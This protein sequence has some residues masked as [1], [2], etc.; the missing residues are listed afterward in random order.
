MD[1]LSF[2]ASLIAVLQAT[3]VVLSICYSYA[4]TTKPWGL[5]DEVRNLGGVL[6]RLLSLARQDE[7]P[8]L[9]VLCQPGGPLEKTREFLE[10]LECRL[11]PGDSSRRRAFASALSWPLREAET[12]RAMEDIGRLKSTLSLALD[13]D[14]TSLILA[15]KETASVSREA[16]LDTRDDIGCIRQISQRAELDTQRAK[17]KAWLSAPDP[18]TNHNAAH[19]KRQKGTG[20]WFLQSKE[21]MR[22]RA[23]PSSTLWLHGIAG[24]GKTVLSSL[25]IDSMLELYRGSSKTA[26]VYFYF[27]FQ[28]IGKRSPEA[29]LRSLVNQLLAAIDYIPSKVE[30]LF[31]SKNGQQPTTTD[32]LEVFKECILSFEE[33]FII[34]DAIDECAERHLQWDIIQQITE[35]RLQQQHLLLTGRGELEADRRFQSLPRSVK[36][37][38]QSAQVDEDIRLYIKEQLLTDRKLK[39]W[40]N[41]AD[42]K[43]EI[44][45]EL[46]NKAHGMFRWA[47]CQLDA[48]GNCLSPSMLRKRLDSLPATMDDMYTQAITEIDEEHADLVVK[49]LKWLTYSARPL[50]V[51]E[52][53]EIATIDDKS[54]QFNHDQRLVDP[55]DILN[56]CPS[57]FVATAPDG[58]RHQSLNDRKTQQKVRLAHLSVKEFLVSDRIR[59]GPAKHCALSAR[60]AHAVTARDCLAYLLQFRCPYTSIPDTVKSSPLLSYATNYWPMHVTLSG[61]DTRDA[62]YPLVLEL[63]NSKTA[64]LNWASFLD[65]YTPFDDV[66]TEDSF[67]QPPSPLYYAA[68]FGLSTVVKE[69][70][71]TG[72][73]VNGSNGPAGSPLA[74]A[75]LSGHTETVQTLIDNGA[76]VNSVGPLGS[77]LHVAASEGHVGVVEALL[78]AGADPNIQDDFGATALGVARKHMRQD[79]VQ[80]LSSA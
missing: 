70:I 24:C 40:N 49:V 79:I 29:M 68:S 67:N 50:C 2:T 32:L 75:A 11:A 21:F 58:P 62:C 41:R 5:C 53:A 4:S 13:A 56:I 23:D 37:P 77:P 8:S 42:I 10:E 63:F 73:P 52:L 43:E 45:E 80:L 31:A 19:R 14:Q 9:R 34:V 22:W 36:V 47:A 57:I 38:I 76:I 26:T 71:N 46:V 30:V 55:L 28:D 69:L 51:A 39:R 78:H 15:I 44:M 61:Q 18:S 59:T 65:G 1:P 3:N 72:R 60:D 54:G 7:L 74:V 20:E 17:V 27:D 64:Y 35:W 12:R 33:V 16:I 48:L 6:E 25:I 66:A